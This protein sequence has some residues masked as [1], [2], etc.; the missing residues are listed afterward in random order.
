MKILLRWLKRRIRCILEM[1]SNNL[2]L[3][4]FTNI[5]AVGY[6]VWKMNHRILGYLNAI[7]PSIQTS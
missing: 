6:C 3:T 4:L 5:T 1:K 7:I 2:K